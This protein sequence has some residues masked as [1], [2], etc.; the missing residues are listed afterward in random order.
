[1][2]MASCMLFPFKAIR[3][4]GREG[5]PQVPIP[6]RTRL[7]ASRL[8]V[9]DT[10]LGAAAFDDGI[11]D[12]RLELRLGEDAGNAGFG[13]LLPQLA[14]APRAGHG[15]R[16]HRYGSGHAQVESVLEIL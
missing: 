3:E 13:D 16:C 14:D 6:P 2:T 9:E 4:T 12:G 10:C 1:M 8:W 11:D 5:L 7:E 15:V